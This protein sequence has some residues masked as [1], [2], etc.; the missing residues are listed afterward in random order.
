MSKSVATYIQLKWATFFFLEKES[1]VF[2]SAHIYYLNQI[3]KVIFKSSQINRGKK[4]KYFANRIRGA[5]N[6]FF[7]YHI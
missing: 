5:T 7:I 3:G 6:F 4:I 1:N 2:L